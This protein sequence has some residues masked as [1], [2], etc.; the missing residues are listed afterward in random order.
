MRSPFVIPSSA[1][2]LVDVREA[3]LSPPARLISGGSGHAL[4]EHPSGSILTKCDIRGRAQASFVRPLHELDLRDERGL[5]QVTSERRTRGTG[6]STNGESG[7]SSGASSLRRR[8]I[9]P[10][11]NPVPTL[12]AQHS[13][14]VLH[15]GD[16]RA[17]PSRSAPLP[18]RVPGDHHLLRLPELQLLPVGRA[19][20]RR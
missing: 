4:D 13:T 12:P 18:A 7:R 14:R 15:S 17:E 10:S 8:L 16:E 2:L 5:D 20:S 6:T 9:S 1:E 19:P 3:Q 11:E